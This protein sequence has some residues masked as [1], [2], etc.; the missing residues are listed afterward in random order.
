MQ[1]NVK[2]QMT[3]KESWSQCKSIKTELFQPIF[4]KYHENLYL[5]QSTERRE[6]GEEL[7]RLKWN[8]TDLTLSLVKVYV[9]NVHLSWN[10]NPLVYQSDLWVQKERRQDRSKENLFWR[11]RIQK[12]KLVTFPELISESE[13][14]IIKGHIDLQYRDQVPAKILKR[15]SPRIHNLFK[16]RSSC[17]DLLYLGILFVAECGHPNAS[18]DS[19]CDPNYNL[20]HFSEIKLHIFDLLKKSEMILIHETLQSVYTAGCGDR[21]YC[22][23]SLS[24]SRVTLLNERFVIVGVS[25]DLGWGDTGSFR[26]YVFE[27]HIRDFQKAKKGKKTH[28]PLPDAK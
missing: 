3:Q 23:G 17:T 12:D 26:W 16:S 20:V 28:Y 1:Q 10:Y 8:F 6:K 18:I 21:Q 13:T 24:V 2:H 15:I 25:H 22:S 11:T 5:I 27:L 14:K 19:T 9:S 7:Y 4:F